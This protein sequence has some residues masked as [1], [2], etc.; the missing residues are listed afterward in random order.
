MIALHTFIKDTLYIILIKL[1]VS[2]NHVNITIAIIILY[3][4][5]NFIMIIM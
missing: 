1:K 2:V 3:I 5:H 4:I